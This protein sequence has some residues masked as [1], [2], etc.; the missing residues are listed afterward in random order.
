MAVKNR[1]FIAL[2]AIAIH[3]SIGSA[4]AYSVFQN[5]LNETLGWEQTQVSLAF[6]IAIFFLGISAAF[7]GPFVE[8][9]GPRISAMTAAV[10]FTSG[11]VISGL[12]VSVNS[13]LLFLLGYGV[14]GGMGLGLGYISPVST[15][16]KWF[17]DR[18]GLATGM[19]VLGFGAGALVASPAAASLINSLGIAATFYVLAAI[20]FVLMF[21]GAL[22]IARPPEG[23]L[24]ESMKDSEGTEKKKIKRDLAQMTSKEAVKTKRFWMLW[25][26]MFINISVGIMIISV[27]SPLAQEKVG[28]SAI[29][30]ASMVG[31]MGIFNGG[32]RIVWASASDYIGRGRTFAIFFGIQLA[33]FMILP[34]ITN[35]LLFQ[36]LIFAVISIYGG[37]FAS[38]PAFIG[39]LFGTKQLGAIHGLLLTS[40]SM[41]GVVGPM[42]VSVVRS[43]TGSYDAIFYLF[44][45]LIAAA[46]IISL[47]LMKNIKDIEKVAEEEERI[48]KMA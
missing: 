12:A 37:G 43:M 25:T 6:T 42:T 3:M 47:R 9:K 19:A 45:V 35:I 32:G 40:W 17:P 18:R 15:L 22:Y 44:A 2:S 5:P 20:F 26:M 1:W 16:V 38:L 21:S 41:A 30:A 4:Y 39:D 23:W 27:A 24:P 8:K 13:L 34:T 7:F 29:A 36:I 31:I 48:E 46:F 10:L 14:I 33:A 11:L 28:M